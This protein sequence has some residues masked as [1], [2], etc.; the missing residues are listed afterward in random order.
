MQREDFFS[1]FPLFFLCLGFFP[2]KYFLF[3]FLWLLDK[4]RARGAAEE[5]GGMEE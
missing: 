5:E 3:E 2:G 4:R 1:F